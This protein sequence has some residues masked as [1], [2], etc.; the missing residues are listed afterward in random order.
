MTI[1]LEAVLVAFVVAA[2]VSAALLRDVLGAIV[3]FASFSLGLSV[4]WVILSAP[5]VALTEAAVGAGV[6]SVLFLVTVSKTARPDTDTLVSSVDYKAVAAVGLL[7]VVLLATVP[8][9]PEVGSTEAPA[10]QETVDG[11]RTPYG[12]YIAESY[13][14]TGVENAVSAILVFYRGFDTF[15]EGVVVFSALVGMLV[16]FRKEVLG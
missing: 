15:G 14:E 9:L 8:A 4:I 11:E 2:A 16:V 7:F 12:Y 10:V 13:E 6:L 1:A 5:D 3:V